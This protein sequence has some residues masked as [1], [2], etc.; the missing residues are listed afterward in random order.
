MN[1]SPRNLQRPVTQ[2]FSKTD[3]P[4]PALRQKTISSQVTSFLTLGLVKS[5]FEDVAQCCVCGA[6][7]DSTLLS[8]KK[9]TCRFCKKTV[10]EAHSLS[11]R[12]A[13]PGEDEVRICDSCDIA[14]KQRDV[15]KEFEVDIHGYSDRIL[16]L[17]E[18]KD[19]SVRENQELATTLASLE[20]QLKQKTLENQQNRQRFEA[21]RQEI[22]LKV[23]K[24]DVAKAQL[25]L[26]IDERNR[27]KLAHQ[28]ECQNMEARVEA[29]K[30][31]VLKETAK[32]EELWTH[33]QDLRQK[34]ATSL[35]A[36]FIEPL[37]CAICAEKLQSK[38]R[39]GTTGG[40]ERSFS[41]YSAHSSIG[42]GDPLEPAK[43]NCTLI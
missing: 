38:D 8:S 34:Q 24:A 13:R 7:L 18:H 5:E 1:P 22:R 12:A 33:L 28:E 35:T 41:I 30:T 25:M 29:L 23:E 11:R 6:A 43:K 15:I 9:H 16:R 26:A 27:A 37:V 20:A 32:K 14:W 3:S 36:K 10:C 17:E 4:N 21:Q 31:E 42:P 2:N 40:L 19:R 39:S